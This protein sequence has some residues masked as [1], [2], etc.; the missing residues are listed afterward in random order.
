MDEKWESSELPADKKKDAGRFNKKKCGMI[1][2]V[3]VVIITLLVGISIS[4]SSAG[5]LREQLE[6]GQKYLEE[7]KYEE[8]VV[9][10]NNAIE[11]DPMNAD[12]YLGLTE[13]YICTGDFDT[14]YE[15]ASKGYELTGDERLKEKMDMIESGNITASNGW[16]MRESYY[17]DGALIGYATYSYDLQGRHKSIAVYDR[18]GHLVDKGDWEYDEQGLAL[19]EYS[20]GWQGDLQGGYCYAVKRKNEL[21][22]EG[23]YID[24]KTYHKNGNLKDWWKYEEGRMTAWKTYQVSGDLLYSYEEYEY[25]TEGREISYKVYDGSGNLVSCYENEWDAEGREIGSKVYDGSGNLE[26]Y[27]EK[28]YAEEGRKIIEKVYDGSGDLNHYTERKYDTEGNQIA[29]KFYYN[30]GSSQEFRYE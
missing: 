15:Y 5:R 6:L 25:D 28:E 18:K 3:I 4:N 19:T 27:I 13:V 20:L 14:A 10:F 9:A 30:D 8:A 12:A 11:I 21:D 23:R 29:A 16:R 22:K 24:S 2:A 26:S 17:N 1:A 7:M